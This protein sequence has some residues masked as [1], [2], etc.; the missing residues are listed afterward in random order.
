[1]SVAATYAPIMIWIFVY[2]I[3]V[4][5]QRPCTMLPSIDMNAA[6]IICPHLLLFLLGHFP[7]RRTA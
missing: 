1:M 5:V 7:R 2:G 3:A 4:D 6:V